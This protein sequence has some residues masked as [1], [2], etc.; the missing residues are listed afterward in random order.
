MSRD[1]QSLLTYAIE[2]SVV[3]PFF[4]IDLEF[5]TPLYFWTGTGTKRIDGK[6]YIGAGQFLSISSVEETTEIA[7]RGMTLTLNG[8][9]SEVLSLALSEPYQGRICKV[10]F[11]LIADSWFLYGGTWRTAGVW[12]D[13]RSWT[14]DSNQVDRSL[15]PLTEWDDELSWGLSY[16]Q[17]SQPVQSEVFSG[18][19][20]QMNISESGS[21]CT[22]ELS[23]EN[24]L[25]DLE[26]SRVS[27]FTSAYQKS[28]YPNDKGLDFVEFLQDKKITWGRSS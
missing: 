17:T 19:M 27:R 18:Y 2:D 7:A 16:T 15:E 23:V 20:D 5:S 26:R 22:V 8:I 21:T 4:S 24:K 25:I 1:L 10:Y 9:P 6:N 14:T 12:K 11:G 13:S 3:E 28:K